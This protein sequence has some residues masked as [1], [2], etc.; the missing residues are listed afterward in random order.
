MKPTAQHDMQVNNV[1]ARL[2]QGGC[3]FS[4]AAYIFPN[5][6][7]SEAAVPSIFT[8]GL[9]I[10]GLD[11]S[12][13]NLVSAASYRSLGFDFFPGPILNNIVDFDEHCKQWDRIFS[14]KGTNIYTH[15]QNVKL[16]IKDGKLLDCNNIPQDILYWPA[17][18]NPF[19]N[20]WIGWE[21]PAIDLAG[22]YDYNGDGV[23]NPCHGDYP[24]VPSQNNEVFYHEGRLIPAE[25][26]FMV[27]NDIMDSQ[28]ISGLA[29]LTME[30]QLHSYA[31]STDDELNDMTFYQYKFLYKGE[32]EIRD[33]YAGFWVDPDLGCYSDDNLGCLSSEN[34]GIVYN[35][36]AIDGINGP[37]CA[38]T[39]SYNDKIPIL[40]I[41]MVTPLPTGK[42]FLRD[43]NGNVLLDQSGKKILAD[44]Q[45]A[46]FKQDT[47]INGKMTS[48]TYFENCAIGSPNPETCDPQRGNETQFYNA[49][50]GREFI[51]PKTNEKTKYVFDGNP[52]D[53]TQWTMC[54]EILP[55]G[56]RR[57]LM[58][59]GKSVLK[60]GEIQTMTLC[61]MNT[62]DV[63]HPC[64]DLSK[65]Q[66]LGDKIETIFEQNFKN[67]YTGPDAPDI[68]AEIKDKVMEIH[69]FNNQGS[70]NE[71][72]NYKEKIHGISATAEYNFEGYK[73]YQLKNRNVTINEISDTSLAKLVF[74]SDIK[75]NISTLYNW[76]MVVNSNLQNPYTWEKEI[77]VQGPDK[78]FATTF[79]FDEDRFVQANPTLINGKEYHFM[80]IAYGFNNYQEFDPQ[81]G[82]GQ[83]QQYVQ[84]TNN[85]KTYSFSP[86]YL[87]SYDEL[88]MQVIRLSGEGNPH[89]FLQLEDGMDDEILSPGFDGKVIYK[90][91]YGPLKGRI[92][93]PSKWNEN[94]LFELFIDGTFG[95]NR[96]V[97]KYAED[98]FWTLKDVNS[99][100]I[101]LENV[102]LNVVT[103]YLLDAYGFALTVH[104]YPSSGSDYLSNYGSVGAKL[105]YKNEGGPKWFGS[106][107][108]NEVENVG[109]NQN[110]LH[111]FADNKTNNIDYHA[112][113]SFI[114]MNNNPFY[115]VVASK[116]SDPNDTLGE[117]YISPAPFNELAIITNAANRSLRLRDLNNVDI[118]L[119]SDKSKWSKCVVVETANPFY[120]SKQGFPTLGD[121]K[122]F[123]LRQSPSIGKDGEMLNNG[124]FG[125]SYFPGY[126]ID[127]ESGERLNIFFGENSVFSGDN[128]AIL[129]GGIGI[130]GDLIFNPSSQLVS[131]MV[132][133][134]DFRRYVAGGQHFI[135]V[136][137]Q[138]YDEC[139]SI[140]TKIRKGNSVIQKLKAV[141]ALTWCAFPVLPQN[142]SMHPLS[143]G[144]IPNDV[145]VQLRVDQSY[146]K[147]RKY[148]IERERDCETYND[149]PLYW[150][151]F[152][153]PEKAD[154]GDVFFFENINIIPNPASNIEN[155]FIIS[156][157]KVKPTV[158]LFDI[159]GRLVAGGENIRT[160]SI[161]F[162]GDQSILLECVFDVKLKP[163]LYLIKLTDEKNNEQFTIK[164][165][166]Y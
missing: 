21:L 78:D 31:F 90:A 20:T 83:I 110:W 41:K 160:Q 9:W 120:Y 73:I 107:K 30:T 146:S 119:T 165:V 5:P 72:W 23:Y 34:M 66:Y 115:P 139:A 138:K 105:I 149:K 63:S 59:T 49:L 14:V 127:V 108:K 103:E 104:S 153:Q 47:L 82:T 64:P 3:L 137:R 154:L 28:K 26:N 98:A 101:L 27:F 51:N 61:I 161:Q 96:D 99:T 46:S 140:A 121:V 134:T 117:F 29:K 77:K 36:D 18:G 157:L 88:Q 130:G 74:I 48:F 145:R 118:V 123:E 76:K 2:H 158:S 22:F 148:N 55:Y 12:G 75:N 126:A 37:N 163:G 71:N 19:F 114:N 147:T 81:N 4:E 122:N 11:K 141:A 70:N 162:S 124:T 17:K 125:F 62:F 144:L 39:L 79:T 13:N 106:I 100:E 16:A 86:Q 135:Y 92:V 24:M 85:I 53:L 93:N 25:I 89:Q 133:E 164:W 52:R 116:Q 33:F 113:E 87:F 159:T 95:L 84:S 15:I 112:T 38:G 128:S 65:I 10:G 43:V 111:G 94:Y 132:P 6:S 155:R 143:K 7:V 80:A 102:A 131:D 109:A 45:V 67:V 151:T 91:G 166:V 44:A 142:T 97:C 50:K 150:F 156:N 58:S 68:S 152:K 1:R 129:E 42:V 32:E 136:T 69:V 56:D 54:S 57:M 8:A 35:I 60:P 40:A